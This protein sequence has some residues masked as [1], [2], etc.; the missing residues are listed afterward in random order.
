[1]SEKQSDP[2]F[3]EIR[4]TAVG[5]FEVTIPI[6][7]IKYEGWKRGDTLKITAAKID[8]PKEE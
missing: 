5:T 3:A 7:N 2:F 4:E 1:M 8:L 6:R